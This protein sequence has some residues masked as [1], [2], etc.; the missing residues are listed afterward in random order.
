MSLKHQITEDMKT[1]M[2]A[3]DSVRLGAIR[4]LLAAIKQR[5]VDERIELTDNDVIAVIEK[6]LKQRRDS[7]TA[8]ESANRTDLAD[9]E[10]F[11]VTVLQAYLPQQ[12]TEDEIN[13]IVDQVIVDISAQGAKEMSKVIGLVRPFVAGMADMSKVSGIIKAKLSQ[14]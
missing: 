10:K 2:R 5:E 3:K 7:I 6:M 11:E 12:L 9:I 8:Y 1:A 14:Q 13:A 4:L